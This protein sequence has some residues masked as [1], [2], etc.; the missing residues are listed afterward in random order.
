MIIAEAAQIVL[1]ES[2]KEMSVDE[3][4]DQI[5]E[6]ELFKFGAQN[7]KAVL[8]RTIRMKSDANPNAQTVLF[9]SPKPGIYSIAD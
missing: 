8:S 5:I 9:K 6:R 3:I 1:K 4:Y 7:P 2:G